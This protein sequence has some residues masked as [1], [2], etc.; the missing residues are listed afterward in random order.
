KF[1]KIGKAMNID[2]RFITKADYKSLAEYDALFIRE[3][4][5]VNHHT[6][7]FASRAEAL[8]IPVIDDSLS[9]LRC[10]NKVFLAEALQSQNI[11]APET[12]IL[13][14][15]TLAD[16]SKSLAFPMVLKIPDGSFSRGVVKV[17][18]QDELL[19]QGQAL[20]DDSDLIIAQAFVPTEYDWRIGVLGGKPLYACQYFMARNHWQIYRHG[21]KR[22]ESGGFKA[23]RV[24]DVPAPVLDAAV[25]SSAIM[26]NGFYGVDLK[27]TG[28]GVFVIEVN[29]NPSIDAGVEDVILGDGLYQAILSE[30]VERIVSPRTN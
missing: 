19:S 10:T 18:D 27:E 17:K 6:F 4:T 9:I 8:G 14:R 13:S 30:F 21:S 15:R 25:K 28:E 2:V 23:W 24:E 16:A 3:T 22:T 7:R 11:Q 1:A 26:G 29:D 20:L 12:V 5:T